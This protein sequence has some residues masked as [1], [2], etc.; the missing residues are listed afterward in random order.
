M[1]LIEL[2]AL[3]L[4]AASLTDPSPS[5]LPSTALPPY[6][7]SGSAS[8][9]G[10]GQWHG[11]ITANGEHLRPHYRT[12]AHRSLPFNTLIF[13]IDTIHNTRSWCRVN[14]R[15][16]YPLH[17]IN[18]ELT[19][20]IDPDITKDWHRLID[21]SIATARLVGSLQRGVYHVNLFYRPFTPSP[22]GLE[23]LDKQYL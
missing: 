19:P 3:A 6:Q 10:D 13:I 1:P 18:G 7:T 2:A 21:M 9:Y 12:C 11:S 15:G 5:R 16:P 23:S 14:D 17:N 8:W 20:V 22:V 4:F